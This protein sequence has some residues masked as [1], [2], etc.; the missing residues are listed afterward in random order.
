MHGRPLS[1]AKL[2]DIRVQAEAEGERML[3][4]ARRVGKRLAH[5][6]HRTADAQ[7]IPD[8]DWRETAKWYSRTVVEMKRLLA[9]QPD[10]PDD[11]PELTPAE[12]EAELELI[13]REKLRGMTPDERR[14]LLQVIEH[15][16]A[17]PLSKPSTL[18]P[19]PDRWHE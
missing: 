11:K 2:S 8:E 18:D 14:N 12:Y 19:A 3:K 6:L 13:T 5:H 17:T 15:E 1:L 4:L 9:S 10:G 7:S 16:P